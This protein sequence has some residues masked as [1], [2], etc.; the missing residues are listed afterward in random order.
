M[1]SLLGLGK[2]TKKEFN[3]LVLPFIPTPK[4]LGLDGITLNLSGETVIA[5]SPSI[6]VPL[7]SLGFFAFHYSASNVAARFGKPIYMVT[8]IY[9][10]LKTSEK[11]LQT[12]AKSIGDEAKKYG[13]QIIAGQTA[14]YYGLD[15]P[16]I[17]STCIGT[18][19]KGGINP[20]HG[21][22]VLLIGEVGGEG[23]WLKD[24]SKGIR[25]DEWQN[26]TPL[27][28][29][30]V[31]QKEPSVKMMHDI[32]EGG[33]IGSL[34]EISDSIEMQIDVSSE[35]IELHPRADE[36][37]GDILR[38]P[39]YGA[40]VIII[41]SSDLDKIMEI[42]QSNCFSCHRIGEIRKGEGVFI[43]G[44]RIT[45]QKRINIDEIYGSFDGKKGPIRGII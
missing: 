43:D 31:L 30:L 35:D 18:Q 27:P 15:I 32:S 12:V 4:I 17:T 11:D 44:N 45:E 6:G 2:V 10:P 19:L 29:L 7:E 39:S 38:T 23:V 22:Y 13:V 25:N 8:G 36:I 20:E 28:A 42:A 9:L 5:H 24:L 26:Y 3:K 34:Y 21:D 14:T 40:S 16:L 33:L 37:E 1:S 41:S